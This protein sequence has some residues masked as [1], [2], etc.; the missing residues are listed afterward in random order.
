MAW[1]GTSSTYRQ[2]SIERTSSSGIQVA[3]PESCRRSE[4]AI[5]YQTRISQYTTDITPIAQGG[6]TNNSI[7][8]VPIVSMKLPVSIEIFQQ[9]ELVTMLPDN[10]ANHLRRVQHLVV[11]RARTPPLGLNLLDV[12]VVGMIS[13]GYGYSDTA[14]R[15]KITFSDI[16]ELTQLRCR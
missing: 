16:E 5:N 15:S 9:L 3:V 2:E 12:P 6:T 10:R 1:R 7:F 13:I 14:T 8:G 11:L 4:P